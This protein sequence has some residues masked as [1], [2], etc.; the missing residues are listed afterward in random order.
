MER[1]SWTKYQQL[2]LLVFGHLRD[3]LHWRPYP[4]LPFDILI[5]RAPWYIIIKD[6]LLFLKTCMVFV[7][8]YRSTIYPI[9]G[10]FV[11]NLQI[12]VSTGFYCWWFLFVHL[13]GLIVASKIFEPD[14]NQS[15]KHI[16]LCKNL[17][18]NVFESRKRHMKKRTEKFCRREFLCCVSIFE[19]VCPFWSVC[20][21]L[22][23][24]I[25]LGA[26]VNFAAC[27]DFFFGRICLTIWDRFGKGVEVALGVWPL[28][29]TFR[30]DLELDYY[31]GRIGAQTLY[32]TQ[33]TV[34]SH[35]LNLRFQL[36]D[37]RAGRFF[38]HDD[39]K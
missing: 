37:D 1:H 12:G 21:L 7:Q 30:F 22:S 10:L 9:C 3:L 38:I 5:L 2:F 28:D 14:C 6:I 31:L 18:A 36:V 26:C 27:V 11:H 35:S 24:C 16:S 25:H 4:C 19:R 23:A 20:I 33:C 17:E 39:S 13:R 32:Y 34:K 8:K 15:V 29:L